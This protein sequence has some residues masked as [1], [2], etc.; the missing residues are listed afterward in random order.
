M[1][2]LDFT[3]AV[4]V[5]PYLW[6]GLQFSLA[7]TA[8]GFVIGMTLGT[9]LAIVQHAQV[10]LLSPLVKSYVALIRSI[11]LILTLFWFFF[12]VPIALGHLTPNGRPIPLGA[13]ATAFLTFGLFEAAYYSEIIRSGMRSVGKGQFEAAKALSLS[14]LA[15]YRL[16]VL[17]QV[18]RV[19]SPAILSQTIILFQDTSLVYV[20]SLTDLLGAASK[21][22]QLNGRLVEMY[23]VAA[24]IY[25]AISSSASQIV[26]VLKKRVADRPAHG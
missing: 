17:P 13:T 25:L 16:V 4:Q 7:L 1:S 23:L 10:P 21:L 24:A 19:A 3:V 15:T 9:V 11:P 8:A 14:R 22:A 18:I 5:W 2:G 6:S 12:L 20:L 26:A